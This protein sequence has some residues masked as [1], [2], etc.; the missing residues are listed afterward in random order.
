MALVVVY[1]RIFYILA[2]SKVSNAKSGRVSA[3]LAVQ[4]VY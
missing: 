3:G 2:L 1:D 4:G